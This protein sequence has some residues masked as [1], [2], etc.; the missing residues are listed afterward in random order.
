MTPFGTHIYRNVNRLSDQIN[1]R[2]WYYL[3]SSCASFNITNVSCLAEGM[4]KSSLHCTKSF[5]NTA[6]S[7]SF[8]LTW[9]P[10][11]NF[12]QWM[13]LGNN[14]Y[15][16]RHAENRKNINWKIKR[17]H[18]KRSIGI[19]PNNR[20]RWIFLTAPPMPQK[21]RDQV[22]VSCVLSHRFLSFEAYS[23]SLHDNVTLCD[24]LVAVI[25]F[26]VF[27]SV[28]FFFLLCSQTCAYHICQ[29]NGIT[30]SDS[31]WSTFIHYSHLLCAYVC[32]CVTLRGTSEV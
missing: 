18:L 6:A 29:I 32:V 9:F 5:T 17:C 10:Y 25:F 27:F 7:W 30:K 28:F 31:T 23:P 22:C 2:N 21:P 20:C 26:S 14:E 15:G 1:T 3:V 24:G 4:W 8:S 19:S 12:L 16:P 13:A 11:A